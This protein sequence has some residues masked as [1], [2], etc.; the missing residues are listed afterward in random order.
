MLVV[1]SSGR[2]VMV[3]RATQC[4]KC[5][6]LSFPLDNVAIKQIV[7]HMDWSRCYH[8]GHLWAQ[9]GKCRTSYLGPVNQYGE[10]VRRQ[11]L[12][13]QSAHKCGKCSLNV[14]LIFCSIC[15]Y[16]VWR[17]Y[18]IRCRIIYNALGQQF[19]LVSSGRLPP[20]AKESCWLSNI[21]TSKGLK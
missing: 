10:Q 1:P 4:L 9:S 7:I 12:H 18:S 6:G 3:N 20:I 14:L 16:F 17:L 8:A 2:S 21:L 15:R 5:K 13:I 19:S 11:L